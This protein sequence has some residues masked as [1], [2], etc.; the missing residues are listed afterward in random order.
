MSYKVSYKVGVLPGANGKFNRNEETHHGFVQAVVRIHSLQS[1]QHVRRTNQRGRYGEMV[2]Q[3]TPVNAQSRGMAV[4]EGE[5][6]AAKH[7]KETLKYFVIQK[8][9]RRGKEG[10][11]MGWSTAN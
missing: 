11:W 1:L 2:V 7:A 3:E 5:E 10:P 8:Q 6:S 9:L 4:E